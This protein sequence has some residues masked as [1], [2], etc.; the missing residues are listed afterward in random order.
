MRRTLTAA[1]L[2]LAFT[3][4]MTVPAIAADLSNGNRQS[5]P[6]GQIGTWHFVNNQTGGAGA[7][8]IVVT[9]SDGV[10]IHG[11]DKVNRNTQHFTVEST[12]TL[13]GATTGD[14]PGRLVLS[15][16]SCEGDKKD[17]DPKK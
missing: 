10:V 7:G 17:P 3:A 15:D 6:D 4:S 16:F 1:G 13:L 14:L 9:F 8:V 2:A 11:A 12:G 5:C